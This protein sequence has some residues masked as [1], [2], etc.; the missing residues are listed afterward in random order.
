MSHGIALRPL[1]LLYRQITQKFLASVAALIRRL[2]V[3]CSKYYTGSVL[4][5]RI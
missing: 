2:D 5:Q 1:R 4:S 3:H